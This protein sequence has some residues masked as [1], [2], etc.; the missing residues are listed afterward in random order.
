MQTNGKS[1]FIFHTKLKANSKVQWVWVLCVR[2]PAS[3]GTQR[4]NYC[5]SK[6]NDWKLGTISQKLILKNEFGFWNLM[7]YH[8]FAWHNLCQKSWI[9]KALSTFW[10]SQIWSSSF[11]GENCVTDNARQIWIAICAQFSSP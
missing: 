3:Q 7:K 4:I 1:F 2:K 5:Q 10:W 8:F 6:D 9:L 11:F